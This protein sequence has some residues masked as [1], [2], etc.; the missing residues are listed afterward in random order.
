MMGTNSGPLTT[1]QKDIEGATAAT[2]VPQKPV[3]KLTGMSNNFMGALNNMLIKQPKSLP[4]AGTGMG[5]LDNPLLAQQLNALLRQ[6]P[7]NRGGLFSTFANPVFAAQHVQYYADGLD[8][9]TKILEQ[10]FDGRTESW[11][12]SAKQNELL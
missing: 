9:I 3:P 7:V 10:S 6:K 12:A 1:H 8:V 11:S 5:I 2:S 4:K